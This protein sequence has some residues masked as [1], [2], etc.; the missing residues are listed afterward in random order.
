MKLVIGISPQRAGFSRRQRNLR[1]K[2]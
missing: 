1:R 2:K